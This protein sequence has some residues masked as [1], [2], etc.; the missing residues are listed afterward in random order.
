MQTSSGQM[1]EVTS[2]AFSAN[3]PSAVTVS[4]ADGSSVLAASFDK[5]AKIWSTGT[6]LGRSESSGLQCDETG[7]CATELK[8]AYFSLEV[9]K[10]AGFNETELEAA[11]LS[12]KD[13]EAAFSASSVLTDPVNETATTRRTCSGRFVRTL[14][15]HV[16][17][18]AS[19]VS[20]ADESSM[21]TASV[22]ETARN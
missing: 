3:G 15:G 7:F 18:V 22:D 19:A 21:L 14:A 4:P 20:P 12:S 6:G 10:A 11:G 8:A 9:L 13:P 2:A 5:T 16:D 17:E 1:D